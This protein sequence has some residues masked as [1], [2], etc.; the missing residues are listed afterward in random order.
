MK[1]AHRVLEPRHPSDLPGGVCA[2]A[3]MTKAPRAGQVKTRLTP[4]LTAQE[5]A[6]LNICFLR[7][8]A[9][10]ITSI[11]RIEQT[12]GITVYTPA[13]AE[14]AYEG[15][16]P[17]AFQL[18][19]QRGESLEERICFAIEDLLAFGFHS[20]CLINSDSPTVPSRAFAEAA[21][22]LSSEENAVVLGP[23][24]DGG[25]YLVGL[26]KLH[27][28]LFENI[29]WSTERVL[30]QTS[31][32]AQA[33]GLEVHLLPSWYDVDDSAT[34]RRLCRELFTVNGRRPDAFPAPATRKYLEE[35]LSREGRSRIWPSD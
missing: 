5:A 23:S 13:G 4:P 1:T 34:L 27:R 29:S 7:D 15:I 14:G 9:T 8:T 30:K 21:R 28:A 33:A 19:L 3:I 25:Y 32:R 17:D 2:L 16:V 24:D 18:L 35:L 6:A 10:S 20:V 12:R 11:L 22:I 31:E 26:N